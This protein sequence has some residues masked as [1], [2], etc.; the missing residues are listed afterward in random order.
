[1]T[2]N[3]IYQSLQ[4]Q[5]R[6]MQNAATEKINKDVMKAIT[7]RYSETSISFFRKRI[8]FRVARLKIICEKFYFFYW[9]LMMV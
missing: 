2:F 5:K 6:E 4:K 9:V 1:M 8:F 7:Q 3:N